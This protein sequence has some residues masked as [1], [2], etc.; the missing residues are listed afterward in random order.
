MQDFFH[1]QYHIFLNDAHVHPKVPHATCA[2]CL[3]AGGCS[4]LKCD[5][6]FFDD[7]GYP[8]NGPFLMLE[9]VCGDTLPET[10]TTP[11]NG[12]LED[13][14]FLVGCPIFRCYVSF[15]KGKARRW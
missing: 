8:E 13:C 14:F 2:D 4:K 3:V 7:D 12:W 15:R 11:E 6:N 9:V 5:A 10:N 1:Q